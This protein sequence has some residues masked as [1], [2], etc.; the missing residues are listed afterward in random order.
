MPEP[1]QSTQGSGSAGAAQTEQ[2]AVT[3]QAGPK[4]EDVAQLP[5]S[6]DAVHK[7]KALLDTVPDIRQQRVESLRQ[8][9]VNGSFKVSLEHI[10]EAM[11]ASGA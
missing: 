11:L 10:A 4:P 2:P 5:P 3:D 6:S 9:I 1:A 8:A 7:L